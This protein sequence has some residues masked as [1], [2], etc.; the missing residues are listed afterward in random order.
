MKFPEATQQQ[1]RGQFNPGGPYT[2]LHGISSTPSGD[3][4]YQSSFP[5][6]K[7][8]AAFVTLNKKKNEIVPLLPSPPEGLFTVSVLNE[9]WAYWMEVRCLTENLSGPEAAHCISGTGELN[10]SVQ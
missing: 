6:A 1:A 4:T 7:S 10:C 8:K 5:G 9:G 3:F 2:N